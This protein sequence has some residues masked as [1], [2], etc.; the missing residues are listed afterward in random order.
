MHSRLVLASSS[1][2]RRKVLA[3][4]KLPFEVFSP[5]VDE[6]RI[7]GETPS[8]L[9]ERLSIKKA[10]AARETYPNHLIIG[11]DQVAVVENRILGKPAHRDQAIS[12]LELMSGRQVALLTGLALINT[13]TGT[14]QSDIV[15]F[16]VE[17]R[18]LSRR[19]IESYIDIDQPYDCGGSLRS[20]GLGIVLLKAFDGTDPNALLGLP[21]IRLID[22]LACE[23]VSA[24]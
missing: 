11:S 18:N 19:V 3:K 13:R 20:E 15:P 21:L 24:L 16:Q 12:Q 14:V 23:G 8:Q 9:V 17:F 5:N 10:N 6:S 4:L 2:A 1:E 22:M 7:A